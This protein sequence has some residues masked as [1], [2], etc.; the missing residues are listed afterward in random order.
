VIRLTEGQ[1]PRIVDQAEAALITAERHFYQRG[2]L[3]VRPIKPKL[4]AAD[5]RDTFGWQLIPLTVPFLVDTFTS[6]ARFERFDRRAGD[7]VAKNCP[8]QIA[9]VYLSR[10]GRWKIPVL[11][12]IVN[13]PF[14]RADGSLCERPG[15]DPASAL[16]F[17]PEKQSFPAIAPAP[18]LEDARNALAYLDGTL[19]SEFPFVEKIDHSV[20]LSALFTAFDR[21]AMATAP[22]HAF[23]SP[24]AGTGKSLLVDLASILSTGELAPVISQGKNEEELEK[25]LGATLISGD[26]IVS[27]DNCDHELSSSFLCQSLS[28]N[29][30][31]DY[32]VFGA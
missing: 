32:K 31:E 7:Y 15:Y 29:I 30:S 8:K 10:T 2:D 26:Q 11:L 28:G 19:L 17:H 13:T 14:L 18:T 22:L 4:K 27:L 20:A 16:L 6:V 1:L 25:R 21:R 24:V 9:E 3:V 12:G 23:T 5:D